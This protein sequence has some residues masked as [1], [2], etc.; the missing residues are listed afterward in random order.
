MEKEPAFY[1]VEDKFKQ[2]INERFNLWAAII[3]DS[4]VEE[5]TKEEIKN[6]L[7]DF[8]DGAFKNWASLED[9]FFGTISLILTITKRDNNRDE[10]A[11]LFENIRDDIWAFFK[12]IKN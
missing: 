3:D 11:A 12:E 4:G 10:A 2:Q 5:Q 6:K 8:K 9:A 7:L 1:P